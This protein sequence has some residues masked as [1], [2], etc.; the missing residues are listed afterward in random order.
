MTHCSN[1]G[2]VSNVGSL[3]MDPALFTHAPDWSVKPWYAAVTS[4]S[5]STGLVGMSTALF[6]C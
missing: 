4:A 3:V 1:S 6:T 2:T 5:N